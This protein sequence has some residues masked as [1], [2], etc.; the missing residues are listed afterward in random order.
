MN[1]QKENQKIGK[2]KARSSSVWVLLLGV[3]LITLYF[4]TEVADPFNTTKFILLLLLASWLLGHILNAIKQNRFK[5]ESEA[6]TPIS[7]SVLLVLALLLSTLFSDVFLVSLIGETQRRN[8]FLSYFCFIIIFFFSIISLRDYYLIRFFQ[9]SIFTGLIVGLYGLFQISGRDFVQ[10]N[11]PYNSMISTLGNPN[12]ASASLAIFAT[13]STL[14]LSIKSI[15][16]PLKVSALLSTI[17]AL[18]CVVFS[19]SRQG[20]MA[21][22]MSL[23]FYVSCY[24]Y[25]NYR[26]WGILAVGVSLLLLFLSVLGM[27][28]KGPLSSLI[29]KDSVSVRGF[30]WRAALEMFSQYPLTGVGVDRYGAYFRQFREVE[31]TARYGYDIYATNAHNTFLQLFSTA[32]LFVGVIY[33]LIQI[34][35]LMTGLRA[36]PKLTGDKQKI[37]LTLLSAWVAY[38]AQ[39]FI[40]IENI[41]I[42]IWGW[43]LGG[44][45][46]GASYSFS[47]QPELPLQKSNNMLKNK[48]AQISL[49]QP[50]MSIILI[51]PAIFLSINLYNTESNLYKLR[52][53][54]A[55]NLPENKTKISE[56][57]NNIITNRFSDP[58]YKFQA[59]ASLFE[60]GERDEVIK[61]VKALNSQDYRNLDFLKGLA[62]LYEYNK[63]YKSAIESRIQISVFD[64]WNANNYLELIKLHKVDGDLGGAKT[65]LNILLEFAGGTNIAKSASEL[66]Q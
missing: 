9:I 53:K 56:L 34:F 31:Y 22:L 39:S 62:Y 49:F 57:A 26:R 18:I 27:L 42:A 30:Y 46:V 33:V 2:Y 13:I 40:S 6:K 19:D 37:V 15:S 64:P 38:Q 61:E 55:A 29:Y 25:I 54:S 51:A 48:S 60:L 28:Q 11:N 66:L 59:T 32:G 35:V 63:D 5:I 17:I 50:L 10:W 14:S 65:Y 58:Y 8:G 3:S 24:L 52:G 44:A 23:A 20:L 41:G 4:D 7:L 21:F 47:E 16:K 45:V 36:L 12:F 1:S 43:L